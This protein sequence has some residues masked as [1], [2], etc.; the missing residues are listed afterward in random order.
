MKHMMMIENACNF[1]AGKPP[2]P[3]L[4]AG[5]AKL[6][7]EGVRAGVV[8]ATGGLEPGSKGTRLRFSSGN[9]SVTDGPFP[10]TKELI[11][12]YAIIR[13]ESRS[14]AIELANRAIDVHTNAG[15]AEIEIEIR[16]LFQ[17]VRFSPAR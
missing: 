14:E 13:A 3:A 17:D 9:L 11:G 7:E 15:L 12:G 2:S 8:L 10:E 5:M 4:M 6:T 1:E 16:P